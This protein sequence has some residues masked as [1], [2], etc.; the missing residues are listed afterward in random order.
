MAAF[1]QMVSPADAAVLK[2]SF[3]TA[4]A[5]PEQLLADALVRKKRSSSKHVKTRQIRGIV[6]GAL[7]GLQTLGGRLYSSQMAAN[8][9]QIRFGVFE[10]QRDARELRKCGVLVKLEDQPFAVL[11]ALLES[12]GTIVT[13]DEL[14]EIVWPKGTFVDFDKSLTK[15][16]NKIRAALDDSASNPRFVQTVSRRGYRFIAPVAAGGEPVPP[17]P[18]LSAVPQPR[19]TRIR[20]L[21]AVAVLGFAVILAAAFDLA[22]MRTSLLAMRSFSTIQSL[23]VLPIVN[24]TGDPGQDYFA[25][26]LT[27][28][29]ISDLARIESVRVISYT[30]TMRYKRSG[31]SL[32]EIAGEL[33]VDGVIEGSVQRSKGQVRVNVMLVRAATDRQLWSQSYQGEAD[34]AMGLEGQVTLAVAHQISAHLTAEATARLK[35]TGT[36]NPRAY[37][38]YL[39]G[40]YLWNLRGK[41]PVTQAAGYFQQAINED[42]GFAL[43]WS[44]LADS[45]TI[46]WHARYDPALGERLARKALAIDPQLAEAHVSLGFALDCLYQWAEAEKEL[47]RG[48]ELNPNYVTAHQLYAVYLMTVGRLGEALAENDRALQ[49]DPFSLPVNNLRGFIL[50]G[51]R[52][53]DRAERQLRLTESID[54]QNGDP[55]RQLERL[56]W[57]EQRGAE[58]LEVERGIASGSAGPA[59]DELLRGQ[60]EVDAAFAKSGFREWCLR[61]VELKERTGKGA[62]NIALQYG[63]L[64]ERSKVTYWLG[65]FAERKKYGGVFMIMTAPEFDF[66]RDDPSFQELLRRI[67]LTSKSR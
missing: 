25:D 67:G 42:P 44:G 50:V 21:A 20:A 15:A 2:H 8:G 57:L 46:G 54:P 28:D 9:N 52:Q 33:H 36:T 5:A 4:S 47:K 58:A 49:L 12:P 41:E 45:Y 14:R 37:D 65:R 38:A 40:R 18:E 7:A 19:S 16:V 31:K 17:I 56:F 53:Y 62:E 35:G 39:H 63:V 55:Q 6:P 51:L 59:D 64:Q 11:L 26:G 43:A 24:L 29:L 34:E 66:M 22:G 1:P 30:T 13:R 60:T 61:S 32:P 10:I 23:A 27:D 48:I 3:H